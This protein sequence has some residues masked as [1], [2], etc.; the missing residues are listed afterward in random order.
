LPGLWVVREEG[1]RG[2][3][4]SPDLSVGTCGEAADEGIPF[5]PESSKVFPL[6]CLRIEAEEMSA[7]VTPEVDSI[8]VIDGKSPGTHFRGERPV[9]LPGCPGIGIDGEKEERGIVLSVGEVDCIADSCPAW[10]DMS[11]PADRFFNRLTQVTEGG[12]G[13]RENGDI[14]PEEEREKKG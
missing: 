7:V 3:I 10:T 14:N 1:G 8:L 5:F 9:E 13:C 4:P 12:G 11:P 6:F 2:K